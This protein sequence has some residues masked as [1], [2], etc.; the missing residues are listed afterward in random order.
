MNEEL[1][2]EAETLR[3]KD[4]EEEEH[5]CCPGQEAEKLWDLLE[6]P[7]SSVAAQRNTTESVAKCAD[8]M[9]FDVLKTMTVAM[10]YFETILWILYCGV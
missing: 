8:M 5:G 2:R 4:G 7:S 3:E 9:V 6:K 10:E 1:R